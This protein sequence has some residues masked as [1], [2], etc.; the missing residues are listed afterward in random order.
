MLTFRVVASRHS[1]RSAPCS[2][3][4]ATLD[5]TKSPVVHPLSIQQ[6][7]K[8][9]SRNSFGLKTI[10]LSWGVYYRVYYPLLALP[11]DRHPLD[12]LSPIPYPLCIHILPHSFALFCTHQKL[13]SFLFKRFRTVRRKTARGGVFPPMPT[14][15]KMN[16]ARTNSISN[17]EA[18][19][20]RQHCSIRS[21]A[22]PR[23][24]FASPPHCFLVN[25]IDPV[26]YS[27]G[28]AGHLSHSAP[29]PRS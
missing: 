17:G 14:R 20:R 16:L 25:Y 7:T 18:L 19:G 1:D 28:P 11:H 10:H 13:N 29:R 6:V 23:P 21:E 24:R 4:P 26:L 3:L 27:A 12:C 2:P 9:F 8:C 5:V 15:I 22:S